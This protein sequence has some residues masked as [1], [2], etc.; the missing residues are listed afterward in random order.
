MDTDAELL[1]EASDQCIR[2]ICRVRVPLAA[3]LHVAPH[4][5][6]AVGN[7]IGWNPRLAAV[8]A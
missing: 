8:A 6:A 3:M 1:S 2:A 7:L 5:I 4:V